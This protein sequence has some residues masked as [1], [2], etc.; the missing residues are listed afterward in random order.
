MSNNVADMRTRLSAIAIAQEGDKLKAV[1]LRRRG[2][3]FEVPWTKSSEGEDADWCLFAAD[4]GLSVEPTG[5]RKSTDKTVVIGFG[6]SGVAFYPI[7]IPVTKEEE[8]AAIV[9][10]QA[11]ARLPLPADQMELT[12]RARRTQDKQMAVTIAAAR[13]EHLQGF[14]ENLDGFEPAQILLDYEG[15]VR[16]WREFFSGNDSDA[17]VVSIGHQNTQVC[18]ADRG[19]LINAVSLDMGVE[20]FSVVHGLE[21]QVENTERFAQDMRS[22]LELFGYAE[23]EELPVF[24]LSD[25]SGEVERVVSCLASAG[26]DVT[27]ALP[28][29]D[30]LDVQAELGIEAVYEYRVPIGL[31]LMALEARGDELNIFEQLYSPGGKEEKKPVLYSLKVTSV[32]ATVM[33][34]VVLI[35]SYSADVASNKRLNE[36]VA[37]AGFKQLLQRQ[38]LI[39]EVARQ[40][41]DLLELL[42][43]INIEDSGGILLDSVNFKKGQVLA[44]SGQA[45][46][47]EQ[48]YKFQD[49]LRNKSLF[50]ADSKFQS[51]LDNA[52]ISEEMRQKFKENETPLSQNAR[53]SVE[54]A[55][56][57]WLITDRLKKYPVKK[58]RGS[59]NIYLSRKDITSVKILNADVDTKSKKVKFTITFH[60]KGF[61]KQQSRR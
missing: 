2:G 7:N 52:I 5:R 1:E 24:V 29:T 8:I 47:A 20:D 25:G 39:K 35:V 19:R 16:V 3:A 36:L 46:N 61:T 13:R 6:S 38:T 49:S 51:D 12:W 32:I 15:I 59:L 26:L 23:P 33:L 30:K 21:K 34:A 50:S 17:V 56:S 14:V 27:E 31:G 37:Q 40:R 28:E 53:A 48:L 22:V 43:E 44:I 9:S 42:S 60:Y 55:G 41:P 58:E 45:P 10:L 4:C 11:E 57:R 18:L 54:Q